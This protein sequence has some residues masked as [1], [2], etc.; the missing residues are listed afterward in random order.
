MRRLAVSL[1]ILAIVPATAA[2]DVTL[3][4]FTV[5]PSSTQAGSHPD[6]TLFQRMTPSAGD[7]VKDSFV[8]LAPGLLGNPQAAG[9][10][11]REQLRSPS[12]CPENTKVGTVQVT[13]LINVLPMLGVPQTINGTVYNL[14]PLGGEPARLGLRLQPLE[15]PAPLPQALPPVFLESPV[16]LRPGADGVGLES[17]FSDQPREQSGLDIQI[18]SVRLTFLGKASRG[19][20]MRMPTSCAPATSLARVNSYG[21]PGAIVQKTFT[22]TPTGCDQLP[23]TPAAQ[24]SLGAP[25]ATRE[26]DRVPLSTT[27]RFDPEQAA[28]KRAEVTLPLS[29]APAQEALGRACL[30]PQADASACPASSRV[31]TAIIDSPL[32]AE[33]VRGTVYLA[34]NSPAVLPGLIVI[35][36]PPVDLRIDGVTEAGSF[37]LRNVFPSNPDLPLRSFTLEFG[38]GPSGALQLTRDLCRDGT[39]TE[40]GVKLTAHSGKVAEFQQDLATPGCDP[41]ARVTLTKRGRRFVLAAVLQAPRR[42]PD[43]TRARV[44]LPKGLRRG[45][46]RPRIHVDG[47]RLRARGSRRAVR[48]KL[49]DGAR[50]VKI[51]WRGLRAKRKLARTVTV[52]VSMRDA[53]GKKLVLR[54]R[55]RRG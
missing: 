6:V 25:G 12:S 21:A 23:F 19:S 1:L 5:T 7:D 49:G 24:G 51:V 54:L 53:R 40:I 28:L 42:G 31:G 13:A 3:D 47:K 8:R 37:G 18:T 50:R 16:Y 43:I 52:P 38:G 9:L 35:L 45:H 41:A 14:R 17:L 30:R 34:F 55:V 29:L 44:S 36:P 20:F 32:Q 39:P 27:L 46:G 33:P 4:E 26:G 48:P 22:L 2:A 11:T 10:C 15:L